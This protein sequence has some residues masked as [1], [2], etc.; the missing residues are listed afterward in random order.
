M[1]GSSLKLQL[2]CQLAIHNIVLITCSQLKLEKKAVET[3]QRSLSDQLS[4]MF[5][6]LADFMY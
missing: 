1:S 4:D 5:D 2:H 3:E 6:Q